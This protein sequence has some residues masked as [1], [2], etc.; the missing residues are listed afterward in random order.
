MMGAGMKPNILAFTR[1]VICGACAALAKMLSTSPIR[2]GC[3]SVRWKHFPSSPFL[4][5]RWS[6]A[7]ATKSTGTMLM[8]PPSMPIVGIH[9]GRSCLSFWMVLKK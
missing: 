5:A 2:C 6:S 9:G 7:L 8:R 3:G 4:C 1:N